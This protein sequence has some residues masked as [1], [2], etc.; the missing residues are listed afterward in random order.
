MI[1]SKMKKCYTI[2]MSKNFELIKQLNLPR[3]ILNNEL[4]FVGGTTRSILQCGNLPKDIDITGNFDV[5][6]LSKLKLEDKQYIKQLYSLRFKSENHDIDL[7]A[8][9]KEEYKKGYFPSKVERVKTPFED[10]KR[11]DFTINA[12]YINKDGEIIDCHNG[13]QALQ[14]RQIKQ[15]SNETLKV[16]GMRIYR[17]VRFALTLNF[18]IEDDTLECAF[19]NSKNIFHIQKSRAMVEFEKFKSF[20]TK[21]NIEI[22]HKLGIFEHLEISY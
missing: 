12:I 1:E 14:E 4:Y 18:D 9:R 7:T 5:D 21:D 8:F 11:R 15:I 19:E 3:E 17:M 10:S 2:F 16:D 6:D 22:I 20:I 13:V